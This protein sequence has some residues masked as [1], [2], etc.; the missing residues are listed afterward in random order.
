MLTVGIG[1]AVQCESLEGFGADRVSPSLCAF[2]DP[3]LT[4]ALDGTQ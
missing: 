3:R 4:A 1:D 2:L